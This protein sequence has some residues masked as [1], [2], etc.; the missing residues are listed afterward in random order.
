MHASLKTI[1]ENMALND[2]LN[3]R[4][5]DIDTVKV[6]SKV[7]NIV[8]DYFTFEERLNTK[9]HKGISFYDFVHNITQY[10][11]TQCYV[12]LMNF[13]KTNSRTMTDLAS[14]YSYFRL[15]FGS[16]A[17]FSPLNA[18]R[19]YAKYQPTSVLD[20]TM[21]W[22][23]RMIG[24]C[25]LNI[26]KYTGIDSNLNLELPYK[27]MMAFVKPHTSTDIILLFQDA[28]SVDYKRLWYDMVLTSPPYFNTEIYNGCSSRTKKEWKE[29]FYI[30]LFTKT[31]DNLQPHG[32]YCINVRQDIYEEICV[33][34]FGEC[35]IKMPLQIKKRKTDSKYT[36]FIYYW[37]KI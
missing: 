32:M 33:P 16:I 18:M 25:S 36:E 4:K 17:I 1:T 7:G 35:D 29:E 14:Q 24:A 34:L 13:N 5:T 20:F 10:N 28:L 11:H 26:P 37:R 23:G 21:G 12:N 3:L 6:G 9:G 30:P 27:K 19:I 22:G 31:Y 8:I 15:Y 2:L